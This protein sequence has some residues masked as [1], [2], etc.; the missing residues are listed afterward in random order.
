MSGLGPEQS[1]GFSEWVS[2]CRGR[3][4]S[5]VVGVGLGLCVAGGRL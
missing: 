1:E 4:L 2:I 3:G 5:G